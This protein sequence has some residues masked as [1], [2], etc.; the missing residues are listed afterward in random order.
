MIDYI[1]LLVLLP[2][3]VGIVNLFL[4]VVLQKILNSALFIFLLYPVYL[5][6]YQSQWTFEWMGILIFSV[7]KLSLMMVVSIQIISLIVY[8]FLL[9]SLTRV[10]EKIFMVYY[11]LT[12]AVCNAAVMSVNSWALLIAWG[13]SGI[14]LF[15]VGLMGTQENNSES[16]K[17]T[18]LIVGGSD[19]LLILGLV[20][21]RFLEYSNGWQ[22]WKIGMPLEGELARVAFVSLLIAAFAKAGVFPFHT[23]MPDYSKTTLTEGVAFLPA[24]LD[25]LLGIYLLARLVTSVFV[26]GIRMNLILMSIGAFTIIAAVMMALIQHNGKK[27]LGYHAVSQVGYMVLGIGSGSVLAFAGGLFHLLN[28]VL[29][30]TGLFLSLGSV[31]KQTGTADLDDMGGLGNKMFLAFL[32]ALIASL[33]ISGIPPFNGFFS[34]WMIYQ[35]I[36]EFA[37]DLTAGQQLWALVCLIL[38]VFGSALT[39]ASFLKFLHTIFLGKPRE[40]YKDVKDAPF[41]QWLATGIISLLCVGTGLFAVKMPLESLIY[42]AMKEMGMAL[43]VWLGTYSPL[44]VFGLILLAFIPGMV[45]FLL[46]KN[47]RYDEIYL[48]GMEAVEKF[49]ISGTGWYNEVRNMRPLKG[50]YTAAELKIFDLYSWLKNIAKGLG[51][52]LSLLHMGQLQFYNLW[53]IIGA[54][55]LFWMMK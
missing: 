52:L 39:L 14:F 51:K 40:K 55:V 36:L 50:I 43:P 45:L 9:K 11:P 53:I 32:P 17:K 28:N 38:A 7:D 26:I 3:I 15:L 37:K 35:G 44:L 29:Y 18:M 19:V 46:I 16:A 47:I 41:N 22:L 48:G 12:V 25:K 4:P 33:S 24:A 54:M 10:H 34:K 30:K 27:L 5:L 2:V 31:E 49:R 20:L 8:I 23:W 42:P 1:L 21:L 13:L 6:F